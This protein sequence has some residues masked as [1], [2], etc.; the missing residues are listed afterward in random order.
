MKRRILSVLKKNK[1]LFISGESISNE[2]SISRTA[3]WKHINTLREEG[4]DIESL[5][6]KG[7][8][9]LS[10]PDILTLEE[11]E[12][13]L[14]TNFI[15]RNIYYFESL[16]STNTKAK[17]IALNEQEGTIIIAEEQTKGKGRLGRNWIS[18]KKKGIWMSI[19][20]KPKLLPS[21][22][23]KLTLIGA[24]AVNRGLEDMGVG[25]YIKWPNDILIDGKK[26]CGILTEMTCELNMINFVVMGI[27][28]NVNLDR[29]DF[30]EE[31][32]DKATSIRLAT[33]EEVDRKRLVGSI[34]NY[35]EELYIPF[36]ERGDISKTIEICRKKSILIGREVK[37]IRGDEELIGKA[38]DIDDEGQLIVEFKDGKIK[39]LFSGE[40]SIRGLEGYI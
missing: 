21:E 30:S 20:L 40:V 18:P 25:S 4:Y 10:S 32:R 19:I 29:E 39:K 26:V 5:P 11:I 7:Y 22:V 8:R 38:L 27:G 37:V 14:T 15:G 28:I 13:Y 6:K 3:V 12:E 16:A 31:L 36:E 34:L 23:A 2:L 35:L 1:G 24:V 9:L 17:E 33:G